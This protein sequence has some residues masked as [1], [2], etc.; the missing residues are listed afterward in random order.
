MEYEVAHSF[1]L[2][3]HYKMEKHVLGTGPGGALSDR[4]GE[5]ANAGACHAGRLSDGLHS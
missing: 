1:L 4:S 2:E 5:G 3:V